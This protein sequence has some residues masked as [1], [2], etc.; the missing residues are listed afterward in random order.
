MNSIAQFHSYEGLARKRHAGDQVLMFPI[1]SRIPLL[2]C[3]LVAD[4]FL[5]QAYNLQ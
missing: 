3:R 1:I 5:D 4:L 2:S